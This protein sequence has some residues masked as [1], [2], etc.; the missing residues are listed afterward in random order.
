MA[1]LSAVSECL[2]NLETMMA[3]GDSSEIR[4]GKFEKNEE[5]LEIFK[6][7]R[8]KIVV[9]EVNK[10]KVV[11]F[12]KSPPRDY[13]KPFMRFSTPCVVDRQ[14]AWDAELDLAYSDNYITEEMFGKLGFVRLDYGEYG[15]RMV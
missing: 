5:D 12:I 2:N 11:V 6:A 10:Q 1:T 15:R 13:S 14:G 9:V 8:R 7:L 4:M 3:D